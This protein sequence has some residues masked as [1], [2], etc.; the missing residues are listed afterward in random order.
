MS[1]YSV[2]TTKIPQSICYDIDKKTRRFVW[3]GNEELF[4]FCVIVQRQIYG[5]GWENQQTRNASSITTLNNGLKKNSNQL[6]APGIEILELRED[7]R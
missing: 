2:Q 7:L 5:A 6:N 3:G 4:I 1:T